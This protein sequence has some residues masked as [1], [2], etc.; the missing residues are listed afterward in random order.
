M[1]TMKSNKYQ[2][3]EK[4]QLEDRIRRFDSY[5][6]E[7][8]LEGLLDKCLDSIIK[9]DYSTYENTK[10]LL[11]ETILKIAPLVKNFHYF[12]N[13]IK[14]RIATKHLKKLLEVS[15]LDI[16]SDINVVPN[17]LTFKDVQQLIKTKEFLEFKKHYNYFCYE[18]KII[19]NKAYALIID[20]DE[21]LK[22]LLKDTNEIAIGTDIG[23][24]E[25]CLDYYDELEVLKA[26]ISNSDVKEPDEETYYLNLKKE[27]AAIKRYEEHYERWERFNENNPLKKG[28][29]EDG[30]VYWYQEKVF[31]DPYFKEPLETEIYYNKENEHFLVIMDTF[32][33]IIYD[34]SKA[35]NNRIVLYINTTEREFLYKFSDY[36]LGLTPKPLEED[37]PDEDEDV[38]EGIIVEKES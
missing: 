6:I 24:G 25:G 2:L 14:L 15:E 30:T 18:H 34:K 22:I 4:E 21:Q 7:S 9:E 1:I 31:E 16:L 19:E 35:A 10:L 33:L 12:Y 17:T 11:N 36:C 13:D 8:Y 28:T 23:I 29:K 20:S 5:K 27:L 37:L 32:H 3:M 38:I 26:F